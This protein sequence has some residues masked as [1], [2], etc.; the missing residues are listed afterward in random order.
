MNEKID[1]QGTITS[2]IYSLWKCLQRPQNRLGR[3]EKKHQT[4]R[5]KM[6]K[7]PKRSKAG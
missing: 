5:T 1:I 2:Y 4:Q 3:Q 7:L 6:I